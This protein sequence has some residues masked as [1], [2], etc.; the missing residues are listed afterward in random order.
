MKRIFTFFL[1]IIVSTL[2]AQTTVFQFTFENTEVVTID[3]AVGVPTFSIIGTLSTASYFGGATIGNCPT[4]TGSSRSHAGWNTGDAYRFTVNTTGF[5]GL[6]FDYCSRS[7][8]VAVGNFQCRVSPDGANWTVIV[9][10]Y[11]PGATFAS[12]S[13]A[14]PASCENVSS[15]FIEV[16]KTDE[17]DL[18]NRNIRI[19]NATLTA[20]VVLPVEL[21]TFFGTVKGAATELSWQTAT[22]SNNDH[23]SIQRSPNGQNYTEIGQVKGA[24]T[25][26]EPQEYTFIDEHPL[27]GK[28]YYRLKQVDFDGKFSFS[29]VVTATFGQAHPMTLAPLPATETLYVQLEK[30]LQE[31]GH[32]QVFDMNGRL[33]ISGKMLAETTEQTIQIAELPEGA[34][35]LRLTVGQEV[36][37]EQFRK[38]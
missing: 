29:P 25:S 6:T 8:N 28:N 35:A 24:G 19:D 38:H 1:L 2:S 13:G 30:G 23:F 33:L 9:P 37:V 11:V 14:L 36:M 17:P 10:D 27:Q 5:A 7:S 20:S 15:V 22:E 16:L 31:D 34:Y 3:N 18:T 26:Y 21:T 4:T 12:Y 32:W